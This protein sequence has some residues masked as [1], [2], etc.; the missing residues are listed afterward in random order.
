MIKNINE[1]FGDPEF[2]DTVEDMERA[3][4]E[5]DELNPGEGYWP[6]D[7]LVEGRDYEVVEEEES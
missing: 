5:L 2:F 7:G 3:I 4:H 1:N 6:E